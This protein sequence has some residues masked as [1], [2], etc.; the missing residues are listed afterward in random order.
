MPCPICENFPPYPTDGGKYELIFDGE[1]LIWSPLGTEGQVAS[2][3][4]NG[5]PLY[6]NPCVVC[7][8]APPGSAMRPNGPKLPRQ[9]KT[10]GS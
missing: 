6:L 5:L 3:G 4:T 8:T 1:R 9:K 2:I 10:S 7:A